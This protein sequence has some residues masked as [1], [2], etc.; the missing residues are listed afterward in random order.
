[1]NEEPRTSPPLD[2]KHPSAALDVAASA[3]LFGASGGRD[4]R[5]RP[6]G[7]EGEQVAAEGY[8]RHLQ[9]RPPWHALLLND[10]WLTRKL[11]SRGVPVEPWNPRF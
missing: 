4:V 7:L 6:A 11:I 2:S 1:V 5:E 8:E 10:R 3:G 9:G